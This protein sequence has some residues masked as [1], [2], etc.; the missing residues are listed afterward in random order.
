[1]AGGQAPDRGLEGGAPLG[2]VGELVV[3]G[4]GGGEQDGVARLG[5]AEADG[6]GLADRGGPHHRARVGGPGEGDGQLV[7]RLPDQHHP[8]QPVD[9]AGD[10]LVEGQALV[11]AA[12]DPDDPREGGQGPGGGVRVGRLGVVD[13]GDAADLAGR[14][15]PVRP[16]GE[17]GHRPGHAGRVGADGQG[18]PGGGDG[19]GQVVPPRQAQGGRPPQAALVA[20][21][22]GQGDPGLQAQPARRGPAGGERHPGAGRGGRVGGHHRVLGAVDRPVVGA[23]VGPDAG[24][25]LGV[26]GQVGMP[27]EVVGGEVEPGPGVQAEGPGETE[28]EAGQLD[29]HRLG[30]VAVQDG[31]DQG[32]ADVAGGHGRAA[33]GGQHGRGQLGGGGLAVG[34]GHPDQRHGRDPGRQ[35]DLAPD[36]DPAGQGGLDERVGLG[37]A[38]GDD[39]QGAA[40]QQLGAALAEV[41]L[42]PEG[43]QLADVQVGGVVAGEHVGAG[44]GEVAGGG[45]PGAAEPGHQHRQPREPGRRAAHRPG[46]GRPVPVR[47]VTHRCL[48][49]P[50]TRRRTTRA[51]RRRPGRPGSRSARSR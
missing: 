47:R 22:A 18:D 10:E 1:V 39:Q 50:G 27:V 5:Q 40:L 7:G 16:G 11:A 17:G 51:R 13:E 35:L 2:V 49:R 28:L 44:V 43:G 31:V 33:R 38:G 30:R 48:R 37:Q 3:A 6:D 4:A 19:V 8:D 36:R 32:Q 45:P 12:G 34:P 26:G 20:G 23:L 21:D 9:G 25:G 14:G 15:Q 29:H 46:L 24:L 41:G 42:D